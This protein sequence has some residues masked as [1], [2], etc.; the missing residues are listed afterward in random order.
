MKRSPGKNTHEHKHTETL[1]ILAI[2]DAFL[3][4]KRVN[5]CK[6][7]VKMG[8]TWVILK[9]TTRELQD[10]KQKEVNTWAVSRGQDKLLDKFKMAAHDVISIRGQIL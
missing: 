4:Q 2:T 6:Y 1:N 10:M 9:G 3:G 5:V 7:A 8:S